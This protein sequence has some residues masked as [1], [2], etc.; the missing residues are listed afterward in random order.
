MI[1]AS[2]SKVRDR[3]PASLA[4]LSSVCCTPRR[5]ES[6][7]NA[8]FSALLP[9]GPHSADRRASISSIAPPDATD[10]G[11]HIPGSLEVGAYL[12]GHVVD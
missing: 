8:A 9:K 6:T 12:L 5:S 3:P 2:S 10:C 4:C 11:P 7:L 1:Q